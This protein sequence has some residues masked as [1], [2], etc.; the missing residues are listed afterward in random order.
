[1]ADDDASASLTSLHADLV[2]RA[3]RLLEAS[4]A[5]RAQAG[6]VAPPALAVTAH[7]MVL[8]AGQA[9]SQQARTFHMLLACDP[10]AADS[11]LAL[12]CD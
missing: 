8:Q 4:K 3:E 12:C 2:Q 9:V 11:A 6:D 10:S 5:P 1:M 7:E